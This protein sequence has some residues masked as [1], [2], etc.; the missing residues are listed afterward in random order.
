MGDTSLQGF[1]HLAL[2]LRQRPCSHPRPLGPGLF[3]NLQAPLGNLVLGCV[4]SCSFSCCGCG[5]L[6]RGVTRVQGAQAGLAE[7]GSP[8]LLFVSERE[9]LPPSSC[10]LTSLHPH[11]SDGISVSGFPLC[12]PFRQVVRPRVESKAANPPEGSKPGDPSHTK[13]SWPHTHAAGRRAGARLLRSLSGGKVLGV[14]PKGKAAWVWQ[15]WCVC[16]MWFLGCSSRR[17][18]KQ[19]SWASVLQPWCC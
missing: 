17:R 1:P 14:S 3:W 11:L 4:S 18:G 19:A 16:G 13:V 6:F 9:L 2:R 12:S 15:Q 5:C 10:P 8:L 7:A